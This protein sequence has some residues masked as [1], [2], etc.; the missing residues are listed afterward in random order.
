MKR[1]AFIL[2]SFGWGM[3]TLLAQSQTE[4]ENHIKQALD[5]FFADITAMEDPEVEYQVEPGDI[6]RR[7]QGNFFKFNDRSSTLK[8]FLTHYRKNILQGNYINHDFKLKPGK[9]PQRKNQQVYLVEGILNRTY[10]GE[11]VSY[12]RIKPI[13]IYAEVVW[14]KE[15]EYRVKILRL[16]FQETI[17]LIEPQQRLEYIFRMNPTNSYNQTV[18][19]WGGS[20][21]WDIISQKR[22]VTIYPD[23]DLEPQY[24]EYEPI[25]FT[26]TSSSEITLEKSGSKVG[27]RI[28][29]NYLNK[30]RTYGVTFKQ[31]GSNKLLYASIVQQ[32]RPFDFFEFDLADVSPLYQVGGFYSLKFGP[33]VTFMGTSE[34]TRFSFGFLVAVHPNLFKTDNQMNKKSSSSVKADPVNGY[35]ISSKTFYPGGEFASIMDPY[36]EAKHYT[37][38]FLLMPRFGL[39]INNWLR[40]DLGVGFATSQDLY[41][42][43]QGYKLTITS[44]EKV[45]ETLPDIPDVYAYTRDEKDVLFKNKTKYGLAL[46]PALDFFIPLGDDE[47]F[48]TVGTGYTKVLGFKRADGFDFSLGYAFTL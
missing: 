42:M 1:L 19:Y 6:A 13:D 41:S 46:R 4:I 8:E 5:E 48:I 24:G 40:F 23:S 10:E 43:K 18:D 16:N 26:C 17:K 37:A 3:S 44:Y 29:R 33:G 14:D 35:Y 21:N 2:F 39:H 25:S 9:H 30:K 45:D 12:A 28:G 31:V 38:R 32:K 15:A 11:V 22:T 7:Y 47:K 34:D 20:F 36:G 27:G